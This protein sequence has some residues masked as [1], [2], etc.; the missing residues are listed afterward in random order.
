M[1][2]LKFLK[3]LMLIRQAN[4]KSLILPLFVFFKIKGLSFKDMHAIDTIIY[5]Q[6]L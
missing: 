2:E 1:I 6:C 5:Q 4:Q 3:K